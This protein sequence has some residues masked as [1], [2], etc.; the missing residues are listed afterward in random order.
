MP[1]HPGKMR[2]IMVG[3]A[4]RVTALRQ[5]LHLSQAKFAELVGVT[6]PTV[7][8]W[9]RGVDEPEDIH[10]AKMAA[11]AGITEPQFRYGETG[12]NGKLSAPAVGYVDIGE[13]VQFVEGLEP[14]ELPPELSAEGLKAL[15]VRG[16]AFRPLR[17]GWRIYYKPDHDGI[18]D[19]C[20]N[21]LCV[22]ELE[23]GRT[24]IKE[25]RRGSESGTYTLNSWN[26][27]VD[28]IENVRVRRA[29]LVLGTKRP[30]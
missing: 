24:F 6:Q 15:I 19:E 25:L 20:I 1:D 30:G 12:I 14:V 18:P 16:N 28:A 7:S 2:R 11:L 23:D 13:S 5:G 9:E 29:S 8:R 10:I 27:N 3:I 21:D 22:I 26:A 17:D 4:S